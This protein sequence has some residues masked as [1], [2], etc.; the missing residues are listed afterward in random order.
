MLIRNRGSFNMEAQG[1]RN[2]RQGNANG[3][4]RFGNGGVCGKEL[5]WLK[6]WSMNTFLATLLAVLVAVLTFNVNAINEM[7]SRI[8]DANVQNAQRQDAANQ[9]QDAADARSS[10][11]TSR[12]KF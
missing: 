7:S 12:I 9:R 6:L 1:D 2:R 5:V 10:G 11:L 3:G 8:D 4:K